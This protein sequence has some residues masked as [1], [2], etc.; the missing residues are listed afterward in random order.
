MPRVKLGEYESAV[1]MKWTESLLFY[2]V[3]HNIWQ[4]FCCWS[5]HIPGHSVYWPA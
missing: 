1:L 4:I 5:Q 2:C 3:N